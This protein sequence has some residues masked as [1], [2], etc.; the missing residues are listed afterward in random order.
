[1]PSRSQAEADKD[2]YFDFDKMQSAPIK[3]RLG[4]KTHTLKP[5]K[6][7]E[8]YQLANSIARLQAFAQSDLKSD[9]EQSITRLHDILASVCDTIT[10]ND[11]K[12]TEPHVLGLLYQLLMEHA[13]G[14]FKE[15]TWDVEKKKTRDQ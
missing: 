4:G 9:K 3:F 12:A 8:F 13:T 11:L 7:G 1:M 10:V 6:V 15:E 5:V 14:K 2:V